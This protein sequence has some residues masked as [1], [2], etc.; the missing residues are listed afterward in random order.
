MKKAVSLVLVFVFV[1]TLFGCTAPEPLPEGYDEFCRSAF[2]EKILDPDDALA[3]SIANNVVVINGDECVSGGGLMSSFYG[4]TKNG[5][6]ASLLCAMYYGTSTPSEN[7]EY[8]KLFFIYVVY[9]GN[10]YHMKDRECRT[11]E[12]DRETD[13]A[14]LLHLTG[15]FENTRKYS[16]YEYYVLTDEASATWEDIRAGMISSQSED[17]IDYEVL[18]ENLT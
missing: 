8:P 13:F 5:E 18:F 7:S 2:E 11:G 17:F 14:H 10:S 9:D 15:K 1:M 16:N 12:L 6:P 3:W 4:L